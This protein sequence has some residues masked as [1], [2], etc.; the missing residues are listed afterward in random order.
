MKMLCD[1]WR[2]KESASIGFCAFSSFMLLLDILL[3]FLFLSTSV[4]EC[5]LVHSKIGGWIELSLFF[6]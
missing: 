5:W 1:V 2:Y 6:E 4:G 3:T